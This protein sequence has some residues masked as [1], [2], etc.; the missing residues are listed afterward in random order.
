MCAVYGAAM[1]VP[2][3]A[4]EPLA[5]LQALHAE[6]CTGLYGVPTMFLAE[7][8]QPRF[9]EFDL[10][11]LRTGIM[12]GSPCPIEVMRAVVDRMGIRE[13]TIAYGLTEASPVITQTRTTDTLERRVTTVGTAL[14]GLE[15][16]I[17]K[18]GSEQPAADEEPGELLVRGHG[19]MTGYYN[20]PAETSQAITPDGWLHTGDLALR[21][22]DG[23]FRIT[24]RIKDM[25]IRGGENINPREIEE[26]LYTHPAVADVQVVGLPDTCFVEEVCAWIRLKVGANVS[27][28]D[29]RQYCRSRIAH[30][31][32]PRYVV[33]VDEFPTTV[34]GKVQK[35]KLREMGIERFRLENAARM[36]T[37]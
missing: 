13:L 19:V 10:S 16:R 17:V 35:F 20:N 7:L 9:A 15:V 1:V 22:P 32:V 18:P 14:P 25:I 27:E 34:T 37:A 5:T 33:F 2:A 4:F 6:R 3:E 12:A 31:K 8:H 36:E 30:Y 26:F 24:G 29:I 28:D 21:T 23:Y 11:S